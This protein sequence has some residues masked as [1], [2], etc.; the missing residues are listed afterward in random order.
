[1]RPAHDSLAQTGHEVMTISPRQSTKIRRGTVL[2]S[3]LG[4]GRSSAKGLEESEEC[5]LEW[6]FSPLQPGTWVARSSGRR[7]RMA[8]MDLSDVLVDHTR[9]KIRLLRLVEGGDE[10]LAGGALADVQCAF[11]Q[12][13]DGDGARFAS[14]VSYREAKRAHSEFHHCA[15]EVVKR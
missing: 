10:S 14:R 15:E 7:G 2:E 3:D 6:A 11:G 1:G 13:L 5:I 12:W 4:I 9:W 8:S